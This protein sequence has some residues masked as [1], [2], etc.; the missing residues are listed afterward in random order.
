[1]SSCAKPPQSCWH[2]G[3]HLPLDEP[4]DLPSMLE[5]QLLQNAKVVPFQVSHVLIVLRDLLSR[6]SL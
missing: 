2:A 4:L 5:L 3:P 1:M 6:S